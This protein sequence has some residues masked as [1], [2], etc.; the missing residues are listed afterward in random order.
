MTRN[1]IRKK[2]QLKKQQITIKR[3]RIKLETKKIIP[4]YFGKEKRKE[5]KKNILE[6]NNYVDIKIK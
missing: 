2:N 6:P 1:E 3:M 5:K 4:L